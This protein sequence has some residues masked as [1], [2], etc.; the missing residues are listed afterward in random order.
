MHYIYHPT[1]YVCHYRNTVN[2]D[3]R[4]RNECM[5]RLLKLF[6]LERICWKIK[7]VFC[8][9]NNFIFRRLVLK[10]FRIKYVNEKCVH[11]KIRRIIRNQK[12]SVHISF[13]RH[14]TEDIYSEY[15][16]TCNIIV[17]KNIYPTKII[18]IYMYYYNINCYKY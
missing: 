6:S 14:Q 1:R 7:I 8:P 18:C 4:R 17:I 9:Q 16:N 3:P 5:I 11:L 15:W 2:T 12:I 13:V 10:K